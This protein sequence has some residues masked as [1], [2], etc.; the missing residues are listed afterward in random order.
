MPCP[1]A[2]GVGE[3]WNQSKTRAAPPPKSIRSCSARFQKA[4]TRSSDLFPHCHQSVTHCHRHFRPCFNSYG[5]SPSPTLPHMAAPSPLLVLPLSHLYLNLGS[6]LLTGYMLK[7]H[8]MHRII[9][10][11]CLTTTDYASQAVRA[12]GKIQSCVPLILNDALPYLHPYYCRA[13]W[14]PGSTEVFNHFDYY[15]CHLPPLRIRVPNVVCHSLF[16]DDWA[17]ELRFSGIIG[18]VLVSLL[19]FCILDHLTLVLPSKS[20]GAATNTK[21]ISRYDLDQIRV[22][23]CQFDI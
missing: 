19:Q 15:V 23:T 12:S 20:N 5:S 7:P 22:G 6:S 3:A 1:R 4:N 8:D 21:N 14:L 10:I 9:G 13:P 16:N 2:A 17:V 18:V 11:T